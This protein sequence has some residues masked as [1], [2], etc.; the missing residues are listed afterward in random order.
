MIHSFGWR[1]RIYGASSAPSATVAS[2]IM[3]TWKSG[4]P[5]ADTKPKK[6]PNNEPLLL[7]HVAAV[8]APAMHVVWPLTVYPE[9]HVG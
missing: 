4:T 2:K 3:S 1:R 6:P 7:E 9:L 5:A 8:S